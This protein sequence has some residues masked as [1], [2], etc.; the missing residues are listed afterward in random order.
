MFPSHENPQIFNGQLQVHSI[1][2]HNNA[3]TTIMYLWFEHT[4]E[5]WVQ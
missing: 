2:D 4:L 3:E 1:V 5:K